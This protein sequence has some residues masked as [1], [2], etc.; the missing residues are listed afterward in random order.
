M[1][2]ILHKRGSGEPSAE[3]LDV[4][5]IALDT[6]AGTAYTKLSNGTVVEIGG[7]GGGYDDTQIREDLAKEIE[8][9][10]DGDQFLQNQIDNL[11]SGGGGGGGSSVGAMSEGSVVISAFNLGNSPSRSVITPRAIDYS[12]FNNPTV[13]IFAGTD[14][15]QP[16]S[17]D[18]EHYRCLYGVV[19]SEYWQRYFT[20]SE[21]TRPYANTTSGPTQMHLMHSVDGVHWSDVGRVYDLVGWS[22][23]GNASPP[24]DFYLKSGK[25]PLIVDEGTGR[26]WFAARSNDSASKHPLSLAY[27]DISTNT[28]GTVFA[29]ENMSGSKSSFVIDWNWVPNF[30]ANNNLKGCINFIFSNRTGYFQVGSITS[31]ADAPDLVNTYYQTETS[32]DEDK[33]TLLTTKSGG[34][35]KHYI[36]GQGARFWYSERINPTIGNVTQGTSSSG[37]W[38]NRVVGMSPRYMIKLNPS[39]SKATVE[40]IRT[41]N[42]DWKTNSAPW[43]SGTDIAGRNP[44]Q[45]IDYDPVMDDWLGGDSNG[46]LWRSEDGLS[47]S[48]IA[49][50]GI[51][52][53]TKSFI[54]RRTTREFQ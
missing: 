19:W 54:A 2:K 32:R 23:T 34:M 3:S 24:D 41:D 12:E 44:V 17:S 51:R 53:T 1:T 40:Y 30:S 38:S 42:D 7:S 52:A 11:G 20:V 50:M 48:K 43:S 25:P 8:D 5:E 4:G 49:R 33:L 35:W 9:R 29:G 21:P 22:T 28:G 14:A 46:D 27:Y 47:W 18:A 26:I 16:P 13:V 39:S 10:E 36:Q 37:N 45:F 15:I 6:S 31:G